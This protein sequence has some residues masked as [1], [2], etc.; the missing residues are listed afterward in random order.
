MY[1]RHSI[2]R[3]S[4]VR[5]STRIRSC[6][7]SAA[8]M[9]GSRRTSRSAIRATNSTCKPCGKVIYINWGL[10]EPNHLSTWLS[11]EQCPHR[12]CV[13]KY[14]QLRQSMGWNDGGIALKRI[15]RPFPKRKISVSS[16]S[17]APNWA[18]SVVDNTAVSGT[19]NSGSSP[20]WPTIFSVDNVF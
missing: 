6:V 15:G 2:I 3:S 5:R 17:A 16:P 13:I 18:G 8:P 11:S 7:R 20:G 19:A 1:L 14:A 9:T 10:E 12:L 4:A